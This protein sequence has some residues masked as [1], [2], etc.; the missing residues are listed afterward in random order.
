M[1]KI[2][3][4]K[5]KTYQNVFDEFTMRN[6]FRLSS[7]GYFEDLKSSLALGKE[8]NVFLAKRKDG[9]NI[10]V[11]IYRLENC[12][13]NKMYSQLRLDERYHDI[14]GKKRNIIFIW[15]QREFRNLHRARDAGVSVPAP[16]TFMHNIILEEVVGGDMA[17]PKL[18]DSDI[19]DPSVFFNKVVENMKKL[20]KAGLV[21]GDLSSFNILDW[22]G[23]PYFIDM[24]QSVSTKSVNAEEMLLRDIRNVCTFFRKRG[25]DCDEDAVLKKVKL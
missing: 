13:F 19:S 16:L 10:I 18:K 15:T 23:D 7:Q 6:L 24:G 11:K 21:H 2:T 8:S 14:S 22:D 4:E 25:V 3:R 12:D 9:K 20:H 5:F 17:S 1:P